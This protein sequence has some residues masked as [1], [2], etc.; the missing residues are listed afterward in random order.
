M[1]FL[2]GSG[3]FLGVLPARPSDTES[4]SDEESI[5]RELQSWE[6]NSDDDNRVSWKACGTVWDFGSC[7]TQ[8]QRGTMTVVPVGGWSTEHELYAALLP[9]Y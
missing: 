5:D 8:K 6:S 7:Q 1:H 2:G 3:E 9:N 4:V